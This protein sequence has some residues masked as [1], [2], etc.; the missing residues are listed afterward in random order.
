MK[1]ILLVIGFGFVVLITAILINTTLFTSKKTY[2]QPAVVDIPINGEQIPQH[3]AE[4]LRFQT[5]SYQDPTKFDGEAF[6]S[7]HIYLEEVFPSIH[8]S[9]KK[10]IVNDFSLLYTWQG[11]V[12]KLKPILLM[13]HQDVVPVIPGTEKDWVYPPFEGKI[14]EGYIWGRGALDIKS[15]M[16]G[17]MEAVE[18]LLREGFQPKRTVFIAFGHDEEIG[19]LQ[20]AAKIVELLRSR[21]V[22]LEYVLDEGGLVVQG[23]IPGVSNPIALVGIAEKGYVSLE[24]TVNGEGGHSSMPPHHTAVG[25]MCRAITRLEEHPFPANMT[26]IA[27]LLEYVGPK[28]PFLKKIIFTNLWLFSPLAERMLSKVPEAN[29][30]IRTTT[31]VTMFSGGTK[32]N[33]LPQKATAVVNFR[34]MPGENVASVVNYVKK[35]IDDPQVQVRP[36]DFNSEPSPVSD[37]H[38][39]SYEM[40]W[41]T[42]HQVAADKELIVAPYLVVGAT[43][44]RYFTGLSGNVYRFSFNK[45]GSEDLKRIHGTNER[46]SLE[47]YFQLIKFYYQLLRNS[48]EM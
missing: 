23:I 4:A 5:T 47:G 37:I 41:N 7:L 34:M 42:I 27:Q 18:V 40:L 32:E 8:T 43:D 26:Y 44:S 10:E 19:G 35:S 38:S 45:I 33:V 16:M 20:G 36:M 6:H 1:K 17:I 31:A 11:S 48:N 30:V 13:A 46:I 15:G 22:Q 39:K 12:A 24:L 28:M 21:D 9:L 2:V 25:I 3:L 29:A 14:A